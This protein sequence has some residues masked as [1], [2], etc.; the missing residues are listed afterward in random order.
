MVRRFSIF[1]FP[2]MLSDVINTGRQVHRAG[3]YALTDSVTQGI[4]MYA[5]S[6]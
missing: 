4:H 5:A 6:Q 3:L 2:V 1:T